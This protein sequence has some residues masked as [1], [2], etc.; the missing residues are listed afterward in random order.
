[1]GGFRARWRGGADAVWRRRENAAVTE[2]G[3]GCGGEGK[4]EKRQGEDERVYVLYNTIS[5]RVVFLFC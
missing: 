2:R 3:G 1:V 4:R 5:S